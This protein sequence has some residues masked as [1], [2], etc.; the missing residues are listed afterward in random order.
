MN[1]SCE[2]IDGS[3]IFIN[4]S[5]YG[6][7]YNIDQLLEIQIFQLTKLSSTVAPVGF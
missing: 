6:F 4:L 1:E 7:G 2:T 3:E 5:R